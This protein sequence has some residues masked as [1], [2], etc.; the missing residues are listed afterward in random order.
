MALSVFQVIFG[1]QMQSFVLRLS[2][3]VLISVCAGCANITT[4]TGG[5]KDKTPPKMVSIDP[6]DSLLNTRVK[7]IE[8]HFDEYITVGDISK[9]VALSPMLSIQPTVT[10]KNKTVLVKIVDSLLED[11]TTYRLSFGNAIKDLHEGNPFT[12]YTYTFSTGPYF[13]SLELKG[14]VINAATGLPDTGGVTV[15]LYSA[16]DNDS[17]VVR[18]KPKYITKANSNGDFKFKGLPGRFYR[19]YALKDKNDN[20]IYDGGI[21]GEQIAF[22]E[23]PVMP[24]VKSDTVMKPILLRMFA[25]VVDTGFKKTDSL[26]K[27]STDTL[28][29]KD[30]E[31]RKAKKAANNTADYSVGL[32]TTNATRRTFDITHPIDI[33]FNIPYVLNKAK[34]TLTNDSAGITLTPEV[35]IITDS[36]HPQILH[37]YPGAPGEMAWAEDRVYILRLVKGFAKDT[38]GKDLMPARFTFHTREDD[39]YGKIQ[40]H[41]PTKYYSRRYLLMVTADQDTLYLKPVTDTIVSLSRLRPGKY[42]FRIIVDKNGNGKWDTGDLFGKI[43]PE[44]VIPYPDVMTLRSGWEN[45][46]DFEQKPPEKK[47]GGNDNIKPK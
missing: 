30:I 46:V 34:I 41:L 39:D 44:E 11:N 21:A 36:L 25:E 16:K 24:V 22:V 43:Q 12:G 32:D 40:I 28:S 7:R 9:E 13:D 42:S 19:I 6:A 17:A 2:L 23:N 38:A 47:S 33:V 29:K 37:V 3:C 15:E 10:G 26:G 27:K 14:R 1:D 45:V 18:H 4:P 31:K 35:S 8:I 5:K 20:L